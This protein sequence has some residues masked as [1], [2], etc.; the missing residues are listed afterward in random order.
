[1]G[2]NEP[3]LWGQAFLHPA[4]AAEMW[5]AMVALAAEFKLR[6]VGPC[7]SNADGARVWL[8][9]FDSN[10]T[11]L[12]GEAG[13]AMEMVCTHA[14]Y[15]PMRNG[16]NYTDQFISMIER[17]HLLTKKQV[18]VTEFAC[19]P[20]KNCSMAQNLAMAKV[21]VPWMDASP[22]VFRF[23][24]FQNRFPVHGQQGVSL[25][26]Q[27]SP[28]K[29][30]LGDYYNN[31]GL[32][33]GAV[34][35][36][37][38]ATPG[39]IDAGN[40]A[41]GTATSTCS[42]P[43]NLTAK[44]CTGL[45]RPSGGGNIS[46]VACVA[47]CCNEMPTGSCTLWQ[48]ADMATHGYY[49]CWVGEAKTPACYKSSAPWVGGGR[50]N[51][52][53]PPSPPTPPPPSPPTPPSPAPSPPSPTPTGKCAAEF[54]QTF[55]DMGQCTGGMGQERDATTA[56]ACAAAC[57]ANP[58]CSMYNFGHGH[59]GGCL[60]GSNVSG[61]VHCWRNIKNWTGASGRYISPIP[62]P[63]PPP[64]LP[65]RPAP[66]P[67]PAEPGWT[68]DWNDEFDY[69]PFGRPDPTKWTYEYGHVRNGE[70]QFYQPPNAICDGSGLLR[71]EARK[72]H[73]WHCKGMTT[74]YTSASIITKGLKN[75]TY[76]KYEMRGRINKEP[77]SWPA[78]WVVGS[79]PNTT[80]PAHGE[81][82]MMESGLQNL[83]TESDPQ[84]ST[85]FLLYFLFE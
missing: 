38:P 58:C 60:I 25:L 67:V 40:H 56:D 24:W 71:I 78:W 42:F 57:C 52:P 55:D 3:D 46:Q 74:D 34:D 66:T 61:N 72:E 63:S 33:P 13:C 20:W 79:T 50:G 2:F 44:Q 35:A 83:G 18:W 76:G 73:P 81:I 22:A 6:L 16:P 29:N 31:F 10:C 36:A 48:W 39:Y 70:A 17:Y 21:V 5:A 69:C 43:H 84:S 28:A 7:V 32:R 14:Y 85:S 41:N 15:S 12:Y 19:D 51:G 1:M 75:F 82:D 62:P 68:L 47:A 65:P 30:A 53:A 77:G 26:E 54:N 59:Y 9:Q 4:I 8:E 27:H 37:P 23:A 64:P 45:H 80:W 11:S 49:G